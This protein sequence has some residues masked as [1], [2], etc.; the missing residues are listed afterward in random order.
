MR[1]I[2]EMSQ[3]NSKNSITST[4]WR[5]YVSSKS[6]TM[7]RM[8]VTKEFKEEKKRRLFNS[9]EFNLFQMK[10]FLRFLKRVFTKKPE[11]R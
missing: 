3:N 7:R 9:K 8:Q 10:S 4:K 6:K 5:D 2:K 11:T 1:K